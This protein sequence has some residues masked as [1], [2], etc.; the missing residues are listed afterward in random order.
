MFTKLLK[1]KTSAL[2]KYNPTFKYKQQ[3][4][5]LPY[6]NFFADKYFLIRQGFKLH[7]KLILRTGIAVKDILL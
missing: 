7:T 1:N 5:K 3:A 2:K 4:F 6:T